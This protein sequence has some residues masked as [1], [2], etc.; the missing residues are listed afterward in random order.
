MN[1]ISTEARQR[2]NSPLRHACG[3][4]GSDDGGVERRVIGQPDRCLNYFAGALIL[5]YSVFL[6]E[7]ERC[8]YDIELL[9]HR[10]G[11]GLR[12]PGA[13][14]DAVGADA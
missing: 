14:P 11:V 1:S 10:F 7:A 3:D 6:N 12:Q 2:H 5:P 8:R 9:S 13:Y 4:D